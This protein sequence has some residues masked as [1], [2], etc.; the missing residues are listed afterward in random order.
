MQAK[1]S[2]ISTNSMTL[3][4]S[5]SESRIATFEELLKPYGIKETVRTGTIA[6]QKGATSMKV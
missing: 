2:D 4:L 5:D 6:L 3:E 1:I